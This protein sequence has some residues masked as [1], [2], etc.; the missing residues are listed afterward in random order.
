[1]GDD[2]LLP[3]H[4]RDVAAGEL[5][6]RRAR[7]DR[8]HRDLLAALAC[9]PCCLLGVPR[10]D[11][12]RST[13]RVP[14]RWVLD[15]AS[16]LAGTAVWA[17]DLLDLDA[18]WVEHTA[19]FAAGLRRLSFPA[20]EQ[21]HRLRT[22]VA[23]G[24]A[25]AGDLVATDD[26]VL[27]TGAA[28]VAARRSDEFTRFD[29]NLVGLAIPSPVDTVTSATRLERWAGCP[30]AY[31]V[32]HVFGIDP[33]EN[34]EDRLEITPLDRGSLVHA[35]LERFIGGV[36]E[37]GEAARPSADSGWSPAARARLAEIGGQLCDSYESRGLTGRAIFWRRER[38]R[39][40]ADLQR[41][42]D[43]DDVHRR[44]HRTRPIAAELAFGLPE[45][46]IDAVPLAL[47]DGRQL[48]FR[49]KAD[50]LDEGDDGT[51]H[52]VDYKTGKADSY[53]G[54]SEE[55]PDQRGR[56]LQLAVYGVAARHHRGM[57]DADVIAE[58]WFV[59]AKGGFKR[60]GYHIT[61]DVL[62]RVCSTLD[63]IVSGIEAGVFASH[64][65][66]ISSSPWVDCAA[67]DPDALGVTELRRAWERK[68]A[69]SALAPYAELAEPLDETA[70]E[71][72]ELP[73]G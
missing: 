27:A 38:E 33:V 3:D 26:P 58:Y 15:L 34:P 65:T 29:G 47:P 66:A 57:P 20:T 64:P 7:V 59:S 18:E 46:E 4:E 16:K 10:G 71:V 11:L 9:A 51:I 23:A 19:S 1:V 14:S 48:R 54:L 43:A 41:F 12:R 67:C 35:A 39:I 25:R 28:V 6:L 30:Y 24:P 60:I 53:R 17:D 45:A 2:S 42:L 49:G 31:L 56:R 8:Q 36:L 70:V 72:E 68:R 13:E 44:T 21:E 63:T 37:Q 52:I 61:D 40:L 5:P 73:L 32:E 69:S 62:R 55:D 50:R 22:L